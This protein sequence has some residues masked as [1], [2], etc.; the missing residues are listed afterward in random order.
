MLLLVVNS[1]SDFPSPLQRLESTAC[2]QRWLAARVQ[3]V[4][5]LTWLFSS[6]FLA[7]EKHEEENRGALGLWLPCIVMAKEDLQQTFVIIV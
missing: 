3:L 5:R 6:A 4:L 7:R 1:H 2:S